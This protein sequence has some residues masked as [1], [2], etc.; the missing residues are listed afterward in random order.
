M[1][2]SF[3]DTTLVTVS[4]VA[5]VPVPQLQVEQAVPLPETVYGDSLSSVGVGELTGQADGRLQFVM[6]TTRTIY[7]YIS[8]LC[9][10]FRSHATPTTCVRST[11]CVRPTI[12]VRFVLGQRLVKLPSCSA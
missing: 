1:T 4:G 7:I 2:N 9:Q 11:T 5:A 8:C 12:C 10:V 6:V 3:L